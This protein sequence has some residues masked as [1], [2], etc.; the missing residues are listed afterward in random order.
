MLILR[1]WLLI[2][3]LIVHF[4]PVAVT[5][6]GASVAGLCRAGFALRPVELVPSVRKNRRDATYHRERDA[7]FRV[8]EQCFGF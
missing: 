7:P 6:G 8:A 2:V 1:W 5:A 3:L 4:A